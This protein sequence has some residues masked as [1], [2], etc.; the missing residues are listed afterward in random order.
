[1]QHIRPKR[2]LTFTG[3]RGGVM[4]TYIPEDGIRRC[5]RRLPVSSP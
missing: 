1:M 3:L 5:L 2:Y 4:Y